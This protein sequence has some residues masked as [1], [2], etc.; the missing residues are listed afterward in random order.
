MATIS[1]T[2]S[3][4][5]GQAVLPSRDRLP[6]IGVVL[7]AKDCPSSPRR[8]SPAAH[9]SLT[10]VDYVCTDGFRSATVEPICSVQ[11]DF[12]DGQCSPRFASPASGAR[13]VCQQASPGGDHV[14]NVL[15]KSACQGATVLG[16]PRN[17]RCLAPTSICYT[18]TGVPAYRAGGSDSRRPDGTAIAC[19]P[20]ETGKVPANTGQRGMAM[21][22]GG[23]K[24]RP[25][26]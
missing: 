23:S 16:P 25:A 7:N 15:W 6:A 17:R 5:N 18:S 1:R 4:S 14:V 22:L 19:G 24:C 8:P 2:A 10:E 12:T 26:S 21:P 13:S 3:V 9:R 20:H 11:Y